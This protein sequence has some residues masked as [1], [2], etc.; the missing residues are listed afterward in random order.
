MR[1][2]RARRHQLVAKSGLCVA[3][4]GELCFFSGV[5]GMLGQQSDATTT[6]SQR[7][8]VRPLNLEYGELLLGN[9]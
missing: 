4:F 1:I 8:S 5:T 9:C 7:A 2:N 6:G 3:V